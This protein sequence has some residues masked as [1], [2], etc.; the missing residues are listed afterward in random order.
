LGEHQ[1]F[2]AAVSVAVLKAL[3]QRGFAISD[4]HIAQGLA[5]TKWAGRFEILRENPVFVLD[6][7][8]NPQAAQVVVDTC[9][10]LFPDKKITFLYGTLADKEYKEMTDILL[11]VAGKI[12]TITPDSP[13][14]LQAEDLKE[15]INAA[16]GNAIA[17]ESIEKGVLKALESVGEDG[18]ICAL[19]SLY[20]IE[21]VK[22][23]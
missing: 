7:A 20:I 15:Y 2:N 13:R 1:K 9:R 19:G 5:N 10:A 14:A 12:Y 17:C 6:G 16:G 8:H 18:M 21:G 23:I 22:K 11:S 4:E 3:R